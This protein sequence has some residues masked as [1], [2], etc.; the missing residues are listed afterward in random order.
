MVQGP[1]LGG[2]VLTAHE[3]CRCHAFFLGHA[4]FQFFQWV[5]S[6]CVLLFF[7]EETLLARETKPTHKASHMPAA[8][9]VDKEW[10]Q[11]L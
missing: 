6:V 4:F 7:F 1:T 9:V 5:G 11:A 10:N 8:Q 3:L 2:V